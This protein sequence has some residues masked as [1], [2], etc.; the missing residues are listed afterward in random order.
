MRELHRESADTTRGTVDEHRSQRA[1]G[2]LALDRLIR[3]QSCSRQRSHLLE[4]DGRWDLR[5]PQRQTLWGAP[6]PKSWF[7]E[8]TLFADTPPRQPSYEASPIIAA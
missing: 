1:D 8:G 4:G 7:E 3:R 2:E 6:A 5:D